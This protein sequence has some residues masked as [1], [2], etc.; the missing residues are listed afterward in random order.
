MAHCEPCLALGHQ[1]PGTHETEDGRPI[2][3]FC[4]DSAECPVQRKMR[5]S[6]GF[7]KN[8]AA[9]ERAPS[10]TA[11]RRVRSSSS[12]KQK[13]GVTSMRTPEPDPTSTPKKI[14]VRPGCTVELSAANTSGR[15]RAHVRWRDRPSSGDE[16]AI[17]VALPANGVTKTGKGVGKPANGHAIE[18]SHDASAPKNGSNGPAAGLPELAADRV[19]Q[20]LASLTAGDRARLAFAWLRGAL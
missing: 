9:G 18:P 7:E 19:D 16:G 3:V 4:L 14:C 13:S 6:A 2:C 20:L 12:E 10:G 15:C 11:E 8:S 5:R 1:C 17:A